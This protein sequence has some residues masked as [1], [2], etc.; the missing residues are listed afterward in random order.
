MK[1]ISFDVADLDSLRRI[2]VDMSTKREYAA[3]SERLAI[4]CI[5]QPDFEDA[6][7]VARIF[8]E[9]LPDTKIAGLTTIGE[10]CG[11]VLSDHTYT[12]TF[13]LFEDSDS[14]VR[15]LTYD[16][17][18][19]PLSEI[20][21]DISR[22]LSKTANTRSLML[23]ANTLA[24]GSLDELL[25]NLRL[26]RKDINVVGACSAIR[27]TPEFSMENVYVLGDKAVRK[28]IIAIVFSGINLHT[29]ATYSLG[30]SPLGTEHTIT[31]LNERDEILTIDDQPAADLFKKYL[32]IKLDKNF[33]GNIAEFPI[34]VK[35]HGKNV[36]RHFYNYDK[37]GTL[38]SGG[39]LSVGEKFR[40]SYGSINDILNSG[41]KASR[42][43]QDFHPQSIFMI[44][45]NNRNN[46]LGHN[47]QSEIDMFRSIAPDVA[48]CCCFGEIM[49]FGKRTEHLNNSLVTI[50][51]SESN[52]DVEE[53]SSYSNFTS[54]TQSDDILPLS[55]RIYN[56]LRVTSEEYAEIKSKELRNE[57]EIQKAANEAKTQF[58]SS[59]SHEIRTPIHASVGMTEMII[60]ES[61]E[62]NIIEY[63]H[64]AKSAQ[65]MLLNI[66]NAVLDFSRIEAGKMEILEEEYSLSHVLNDLNN[67]VSEKAE[68]KNLNLS[69]NV[70][71]AV[72]D[73]LFGDEVRIRQVLLNLLN[74]A[75]KYTF[76]GSIELSLSYEVISLH[77]IALIF[78]VKDTGIGM[79]NEDIERLFSPFERAYERST[80][81]IEGTGLGMT[82]ARRLL[83]LM[84]SDL[85][86]TSQYGVGSDFSFRLIQQVSDWKPMG[87]FYENVKR[88]REM[89]DQ[90]GTSSFIAPDAHILAVDDIPL[91][92]TVLK[93]LLKRTKIQ[94]DSAESGQAAIEL[95]KKNKYD[96]ILMDH[97]MPGMSGTEA[98]LIIKK[99]AP[100]SLNAETPVIILTASAVAGMREKFLQSGFDDYLAKPVK[101]DKLEDMIMKYLPPALIKESD[102][103][104]EEEEVPDGRI[105]EEMIQNSLSEIKDLDYREGLKLCGEWDTYLTILREFSDSWPRQADNLRQYITD[106]DL[107]NYTIIVHALK[108]SARLLGAADISKEAALLE[109]LGEEGDLMTI[110]SRSYSFIKRCDSIREALKEVIDIGQNLS[111]TNSEMISME[112][113]NDAYSAISEYA[114]VY[115]MD[116]ADQIMKKLLTYRI[117]PSEEIRFK[118]VQSLMREVQYDELIELLNKGKKDE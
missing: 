14:E 44:L 52:V 89:P 24:I 76:S 108:N 85:Y 10:I 66:V 22:V 37:N 32:N 34:I 117:P 45:C 1:Q 35:R 70:D 67:M 73:P 111:L 94:V 63:A 46:Y 50:A 15:V 113:L 87:D 28:G 41:R 30:W 69:F 78:H 77:S 40:L 92:H 11:G 68:E 43:L 39:G 84:G 115:D 6:T 72:P 29:S 18:M 47:Q 19:D 25:D 20:G 95:C 102:E 99:P 96:I 51:F 103:T 61:R 65:T 48:G 74:N 116:S 5:D 81:S 62:S 101:A 55:D 71:P 49:S 60:R 26:P 57:I 97:L 53:I 104:I 64:N 100:D 93:S 9:I 86:V 36:A 118:R 114:S 12:V 110:R 59:M 7:D 8:Y 21:A 3:A 54:F 98:M 106:R 79:K 42:S 31:A 56:L 105:T 33:I 109:K 23:L 16:C 88:A 58:L 13:M 90:N 91:N 82:I 38:R 83:N 80:H 2:L 17:D 112:D 27:F 4:I 75:V 107:R